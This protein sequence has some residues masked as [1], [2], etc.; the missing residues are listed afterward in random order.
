MFFVFIAP[1]LLEQGQGTHKDSTLESLCLSLEELGIKVVAASADDRP[2]R[3]VHGW[4]HACL[5]RQEL[6]A[7]STGLAQRIRDASPESAPPEIQATIAD[8]PRRFKLLYTDTVLHMFNGNGQYAIPAYMGTLEGLEK[9]LGPVI[10]WVPNP[11]NKMMPAP[12]ARRLP[13]YQSTLDSL[14]P[15]AE[16]LRV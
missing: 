10:G 15:D 16:Q 6:R 14:A 9:L 8:F 4:N 7:I 5:T 11:E 3:E 1:V 12:M 13:A 2:V